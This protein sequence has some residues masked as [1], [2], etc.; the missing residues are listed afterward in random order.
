MVA[1]PAIPPVYMPVADPMVAI[2][3]LLLL[4]VPSATLF[5][6]RPVLPSQ[7][8]VVP[9]MAVG[10]GITVTFITIVSASP[11]PSFTTIEKASVPL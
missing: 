4:H 3:V 2:T 1:V 11:I 9:V 8:A 10:V 5:N 7:K 6:S